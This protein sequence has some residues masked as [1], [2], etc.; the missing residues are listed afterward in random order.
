MIK[1]IKT[2]YENLENET[3]APL[4]INLFSKP[5]SFNNLSGILLTNKE[6][7]KIKSER[8]SA[9]DP[10]QFHEITRDNNRHV[11][12]SNQWGEIKAK[13]KL[14]HEQKIKKMVEKAYRSNKQK[15]SSQQFLQSIMTLYF[16]YNKNPNTFIKFLE[17]KLHFEDP[18]S[19]TDLLNAS[20]KHIRTLSNQRKIDYMKLKNN[21]SFKRSINSFKQALLRTIEESHQRSH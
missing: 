15:F 21:I 19:F 2:I 6:I 18:L 5:V 9:D 17:E 1:R 14:I 12:Y 4:I 20:Y 8:I 3:N 10:I 11:I 16:M 7:S 13:E